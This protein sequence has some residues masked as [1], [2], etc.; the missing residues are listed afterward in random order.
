MVRG[1]IIILDEYALDIFR[2]ETKAVDEYFLKKFG[3]MPK[4]KK[5]SW[6]SVPSGYIEVDW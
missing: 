1:G 4:I 6:H 3:K 2:G 5:F